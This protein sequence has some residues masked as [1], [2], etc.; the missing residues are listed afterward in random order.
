MKV[1]DLTVA[2]VVVALYLALTTVNPLGYGPIQF[3]IS[4]I[5][6]MLPFWD[7]KYRVA[8]LVAVG[9]ANMFSPM[10]IIDVA[11]GLVIGVIAYY[12][13]MSVLKSKWQ[14][15]IGYSVICGIIV[16]AALAWMYSMP[17]VAAATSVFVS[18]I[19]I[20]FIGIAVL[21]KLQKVGII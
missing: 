9:V 15:A 11:V 16:G 5:I 12:P 17:Y 8:S 7:K 20:T 3:R 13:M 19:I 21:N 14:L 1:K 18:Q 4:E 6:L 2:G 10:G